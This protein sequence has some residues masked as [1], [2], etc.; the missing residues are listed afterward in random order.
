[1]SG[2]NAI[3]RGKAG[4]DCPFLIPATGLTH[5]RGTPR[6]PTEFKRDVKLRVRWATA[7]TSD[8]PA[9]PTQT[10]L[11]AGPVLATRTA[12]KGVAGVQRHFGRAQNARPGRTKRLNEKGLRA[13]IA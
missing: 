6:V 4:H 10:E 3:A 13:S 8:A 7:Q 11:T 2:E 9:N 5:G 12:L 1:V